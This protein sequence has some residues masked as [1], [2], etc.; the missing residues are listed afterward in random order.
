MEFDKYCDWQSYF[1][2]SESYFYC[3]ALKHKDDIDCFRAK[4]KKEARRKYAEYGERTIKVPYISELEDMRCENK[5]FI[6]IEYKEETLSPNQIFRKTDK[7]SLWRGSLEDDLEY[8]SISSPCSPPHD[9]DVDNFGRWQFDKWVR[10][11]ESK[12][13]HLQKLKEFELMYNSL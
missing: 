12:M 1:G 13:N 11:A 6:C 9:I 7:A 3:L 10:E 5:R 8:I 4:L 2:L